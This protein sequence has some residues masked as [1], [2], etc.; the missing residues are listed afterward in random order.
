MMV[1]PDEFSS[2]VPTPALTAREMQVLAS[3]M[4]GKTNREIGRELFIAESTVKTYVTSIFLKF[5]VSTRVEAAIVGWETFPHVA[6]PSDSSPSAHRSGLRVD[7]SDSAVSESGRLVSRWFRTLPCQRVR[8]RAAVLP[9]R[10]RNFPS[11]RLA[12]RDP[13]LAIPAEAPLAVQP[14]RRRAAV[15]LRRGMCSLR[16]DQ[17]DRQASATPR[18]RRPSAGER[19]RPTPAPVERGDAGEP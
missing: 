11:Y 17:I 9:M 8:R 15:R 19:P 10:A 13:G 5:G 2:P 7:R 4:L 18:A 1:P 3:L 12:P 6:S 16:L 14:G